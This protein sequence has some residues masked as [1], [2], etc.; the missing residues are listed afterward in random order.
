MLQPLLTSHTKRPRRIGG[1]SSCH[2]RVTNLIDALPPNGP[3]LDIRVRIGLA[4]RPKTVLPTCAMWYRTRRR[5]PKGV[6]LPSAPVPPAHAK[7]RDR[8]D[9]DH[10][11]TNRGAKATSYTVTAV[12]GLTSAVPPADEEPAGRL[13]PYPRQ[14]LSVPIATHQ[15]TGLVS[16]RTRSTEHLWGESGE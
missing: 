1:A 11:R 6:V 7:P 13:L 3:E 4:G 15:L 8:K 14:S 10:T 12:Q 16:P 9:P 5:I 2:R